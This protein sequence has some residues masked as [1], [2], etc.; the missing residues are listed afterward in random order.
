MSKGQP[1]VGIHLFSIPSCYAPLKILRPAADLPGKMPYNPLSVLAAFAPVKA[2]I[3]SV[4]K[5]CA[6]AGSRQRVR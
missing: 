2:G 6:T 3:F 5:T 1:I 4:Q